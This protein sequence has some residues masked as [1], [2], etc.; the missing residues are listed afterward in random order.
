MEK[1]NGGKFV[2]DRERILKF[3][4][5]ICVPNDER[6]KKMIFEKAHK[7]KLSIHPGT[8]KMYQ[9]VKQMFWWPK[10]KKEI[11]QYVTSCLTC[12]KTKI[13]HRRPA[14]ML[15]PLHIPEWKWDSIAMDFVVGLPRT[16]QKFDS[17]WVIVDR[18]TKSAHFLPI[19]IRY[20]LEKL[21]ELYIKEIVRLNGISSSI[22]SDR[23]PRFTSK[24][25][26]SLHQ[27]LGT[28]IHLSSTYHPQ[29]DG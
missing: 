27:A 25:W 3:G 10:M 20:S 29:T 4:N 9:D 19:N 24:F 6:I 21:T 28:K 14:G 22:V 18:L 26:G 2:I 7:S 11:A 23:D 17:I 13:E 15:Q 8:T 1:D 12:Q 5:R 16:I